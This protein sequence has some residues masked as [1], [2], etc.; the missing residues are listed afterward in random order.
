MTHLVAPTYAVGAVAVCVDAEGRVLLVRSRQHRAWSL[1]GGLLKRRESPAA[2][3]A[4]ELEEELGVVV[5][6]AE[7]DHNPRVVVDPTARQVTVVYR[8]TLHRTPVRDG[9]EV[10]EVCWF[11]SSELPGALLRGTRESLRFFDLIDR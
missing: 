3:L 11:H 6:E 5:G 4:R 10:M 1:P 7:L 9:V 2:G 8:L